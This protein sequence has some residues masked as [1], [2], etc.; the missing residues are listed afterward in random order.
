MEKSVSIVLL[1]PTMR[2]PRQNNHNDIST[3]IEMH[4]FDQSPIKILFYD[5]CSIHESRL[6]GNIA[7]QHL[8]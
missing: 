1:S 7:L 8:K 5:L 4:V 6:K 3:T 2:V